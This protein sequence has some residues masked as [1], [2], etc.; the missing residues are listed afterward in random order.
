MRKRSNSISKFF[1]YVIKTAKRAFLPKCHFVILSEVITFFSNKLD[2][3]FFS[4]VKHTFDFHLLHFDNFCMY[5]VQKNW[6]SENFLFTS[7]CEGFDIQSNFA[8]NLR[9][10][11]LFF[12]YEIKMY[13][14]WTSLK[15]KSQNGRGTFWDSSIWILPSIEKKAENVD[16]QWRHLY[17][18]F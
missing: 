2:S 4:D 16:F 3:L 1:L 8:K 5:C 6:A 14:I 12:S 11:N 10:R 7:F 18:R 9:D 15:S 17:N 13:C